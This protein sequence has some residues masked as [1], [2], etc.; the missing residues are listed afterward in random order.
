MK[1]IGGGA[2]VGV[3]I[4]LSLALFVFGALISPIADQLTVENQSESNVTGSNAILLGLVITVIII[5]VILLIL[6]AGGIK[7]T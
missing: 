7:V 4:L 1:G 5:V 3:I 2:I 6:R